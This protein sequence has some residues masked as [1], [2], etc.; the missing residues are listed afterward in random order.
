MRDPIVAL[1]CLMALPI[2][3]KRPFVGLLMFSVLAY[4]RLQ[5]LAWGFAKFERWSMYVAVMMGAGYMAQKDRRGPVIELRTIILVGLVVFIGLGHF[6][7][8]GERAVDMAPF[9][10]YVKIVG[11][12]IFTTCVIH[13]KQHL[14]ILVWVI[15]LSL[16][17]YGVKNG[18]AGVVKLGNL[19]IIRGPGGMLEDNNDFALAVAMG[20]PFL[21]HLGTSETS[22]TL[23][24]GVW[25]IVLLSMITVVLTRSRGGALSMGMMLMLLVA[26][27]KNKVYGILLG[28]LCVGAIA[29]LAPEEYAKRLSTI[30]AFEEDGSAMGRI[31]AWKVA[32]RM[33]KANPITGVGF[34]RFVTNYLDHEPEPT[35]EQ[36]SGGALVAH[37]SYFQ[38]W[39][40]CGT[41]AL[42]AYLLLLALSFIDLWRVRRE[43]K[44]RYNQSW[45]LSYCTMFEASLATF[46]LG[47]FFLNRA[48]FDLIYHFFTII[49]I[50]GRVARQ[51]MDEDDAGLGF[52]HL[53]SGRRGLLT[54][55][56]GTGFNR[57]VQRQSGFRTTQLVP[58]G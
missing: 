7:A 14:R 9:I 17:F 31:Q 3:F 32:F 16:G 34:N 19:Y 37:N 26:R 1:I 10:E 44:R 46:M 15:G 57:R 13:T 4:M 45:I 51:Q 8:Q 39:A 54:T 53:R 56:E 50:F 25:A 12:A 40:E 35:P 22:E 36:L 58:G 42:A 48:H 29:A 24:K 49:L 27:S 43:A 20:I 55:T 28:V 38:I 21:V 6:F 41:P 5:D 33:V 2:S 52:K 23:R 30:Q 18:I 11:I 47:S